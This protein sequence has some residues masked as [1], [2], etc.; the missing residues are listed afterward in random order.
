[1][2]C[3]TSESKVVCVLVMT[4]SY[5]TPESKVV[6]DLWR[7]GRVQPLIARLCVTFGGN[8]VCDLGVQVAHESSSYVE[9]ACRVGIDWT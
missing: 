6:C 3:A 7:Q 2:S 5:A 4:R 1:M 8:V 9:C